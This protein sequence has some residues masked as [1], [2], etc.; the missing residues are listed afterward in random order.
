MAQAQ[1]AKLDAGAR[2]PD[3]TLRLLGGSQ[4]A[5]PRDWAGHWGVLLFYRGHW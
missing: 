4:L 3:M 5:V 2:F 1:V